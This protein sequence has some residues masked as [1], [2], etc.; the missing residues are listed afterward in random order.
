M[1]NQIEWARKQ[2]DMEMPEQTVTGESIAD[3]EDMVQKVRAPN[4]C[5]HGPAPPPE[6]QCLLAVHRV[7]AGKVRARDRPSYS[8]ARDR[9]VAAE[10]GARVASPQPQPWHPE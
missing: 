2:M 8:R 3:R 4:D 10:A 9:P 7:G 5:Q 6:H 1:A